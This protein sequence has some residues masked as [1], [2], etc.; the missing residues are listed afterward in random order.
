MQY[1]L[2]WLSAQGRTRAVCVDDA[3]SLI[4]T[5]SGNA[6]QPRSPRVRISSNV[7]PRIICTFV[8]IDVKQCKAISP[9]V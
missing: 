2:A 5:V 3:S 4:D 7:Q 1:G 9:G 8:C 6:R